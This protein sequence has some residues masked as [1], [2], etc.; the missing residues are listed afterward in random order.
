M[1]DMKEAPRRM[2]VLPGIASAQRIAAAGWLVRRGQR[3]R[4][5]CPKEPCR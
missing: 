5:R 1:Q 2:A 3:Q 4:R